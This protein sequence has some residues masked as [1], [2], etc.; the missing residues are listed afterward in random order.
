MLRSLGP[1]FIHASEE[2][3]RAS[4]PPWKQE[5]SCSFPFTTPPPPQ[6]SNVSSDP[7]PVVTQTA[8]HANTDAVYHSW[9]RMPGLAFTLARQ[10][11]YTCARGTLINWQNQDAGSGSPPGDAE[12]LS[13]IDGGWS[14]PLNNS[15]ATDVSGREMSPISSAALGLKHHSGDKT[16]YLGHG[17]LASGTQKLPNHWGIY[18]HLYAHQSFSLSCSAPLS[19]D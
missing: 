6:H 2:L 14:H 5:A 11:A 13:L 16:I 4:V 9:C 15:G 12:P 1:G 7:V 3:R 19:L 10:H 8:G 17:S 18:L